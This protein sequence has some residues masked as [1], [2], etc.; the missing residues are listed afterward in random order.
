MTSIGLT[1]RLLHYGHY[2]QVLIFELVEAHTP[3]AL[4]GSEQD[5]TQLFTK[6][7][8]VKKGGVKFPHNFDEKAGGLHCR[9]IIRGLLAFEPADRLGN[10]ANG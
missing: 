5:I 2:G 3:F 6:I 4:A 8:C 1:S 10:L 9:E 7:A